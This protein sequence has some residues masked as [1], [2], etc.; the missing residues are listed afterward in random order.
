M[1]DYFARVR[2]FQSDTKRACRIREKV[3]AALYVLANERIECL[4]AL[5][6]HGRSTYLAMPA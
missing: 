1:V 5:V 6:A 3:R 4:A 2:I